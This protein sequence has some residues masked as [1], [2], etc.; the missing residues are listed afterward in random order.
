MI[1]EN[2][3]SSQDC[4]LLTDQQQKAIDLLLL[5]KTEKSVA[6]ELEI[7]RETVNR[8]R[9]H[10]P[11]FIAALGERQE[12]LGRW[13]NLFPWALDVIEQALAKS[14]PEVAIALL[15][16]LAPHQLQTGEVASQLVLL[17]QARGCSG[18]E[19]KNAP[20]NREDTTKVADFTNRRLQ[21]VE[22]IA[23]YSLS[24]QKSSREGA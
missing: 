17:A 2:H 13:N 5:G 4:N 18:Q 11:S 20:P 16:A 1:T 15:Q 21:S 7:A 8:W 6:E 12:I 22:A 19:E 10:N 14:D 3:K 9:N 24:S 23:N